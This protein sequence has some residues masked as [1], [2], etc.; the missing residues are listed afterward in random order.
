[1]QR[2][3]EIL[4]N[5]SVQ[6]DVV[7]AVVDLVDRRV[8]ATRGMTGMAARGGLGVLR[9]V[10]PTF[11]RDAVQWL[12]P[13]F[14]GALE[15]TFATWRSAGREDSFGAYL[16]RGREREVAEALLAVTDAKIATARPAVR[17]VYDKLR[18]SA[19]DHV[20]AAVPALGE[21]LDGFIREAE[22]SSGD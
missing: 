9:K 5:P 11:V 19:L 8:A 22:G 7:R 10:S 20:A 12:L 2:L 21:V 1:M 3:Q 18:S 4:L 15:P 13:D 14:A 6:P 16:G 17:R